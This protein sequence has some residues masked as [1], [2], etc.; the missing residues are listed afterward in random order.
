MNTEIIEQLSNKMWI[1]RK[2]RINASERLLKIHRRAQFLINYYTVVILSLSIWTLYSPPKSNHLSFITVIASLFLFA[3]TIAIDSSNYK[4]R[5]SSMKNCYI[6]IDGLE[7]ELNILLND[8]INKS[9][10]NDQVIKD[11]FRNIRKQY[12]DLLNSVENHSEYDHLKFLLTQKDKVKRFN[13]VQYYVRKIIY[14]LG[15]IFLVL[16]PFSP[17]VL[18]IWGKI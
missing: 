9:I 6:K 1:T 3:M 7:A 18:L 5:I 10:S 17:I 4:D 13:Y 2:C 15:F 12:S 16:V 11:T 14:F 8:V